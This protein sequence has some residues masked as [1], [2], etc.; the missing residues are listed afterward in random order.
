VRIANV[1]FWF[2]VWISHFVFTDNLRP[3]YALGAAIAPALLCFVIDVVMHKRQEKKAAER[4]RD[5]N[6]DNWSE[7]EKEVF[8]KLMNE[9]GA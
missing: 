1:I 9:S 6:P 4:N 8:R 2:A 3:G 7:N 5:Q